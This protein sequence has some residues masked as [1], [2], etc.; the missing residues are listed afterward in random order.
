MASAKV[1]DKKALPT[2]SILRAVSV[3]TLRNLNSIVAPVVNCWATD[4]WPGD[5]PF[6][7]SQAGLPSRSWI[8]NLDDVTSSWVPHLEP[9]V[10]PDL[11]RSEAAKLDSFSKPK[12]LFPAC[13][14]AG[15]WRRYYGTVIPNDA[16]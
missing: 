4:C 14:H 2:I 13:E 6:G 10:G 1:A 16:M 5:S 12:G 3:V 9:F 8:R 15:S 7:Q 11:E